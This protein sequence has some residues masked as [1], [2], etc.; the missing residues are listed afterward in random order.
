MCSRRS[1]GQVVDQEFHLVDQDIAVGQDQVLHPAGPV[2]HRQQRHI[3][4]LGRAV[5]LAQV[6]VQA[7]ADH[8]FPGV[9]AVLGDRQHMVAGQLAAAEALAAVH[10]QVAVAGEQGGIGERRRRVDGVVAAVAGAGDDGVQG[11]GALQAADTVVAAVDG[12]AGIAQGPR[13]GVA[14]VEA[15]RFLPADPVKNS[16]GGVQRQHAGRM[17]VDDAS[18][19][20]HQHA[21]PSFNPGE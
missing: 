17:K 11:Q 13:H 1:R 3:G 12:D 16:A 18:R 20:F 6:A 15:N 7:G 4:L 10:A 19:Y 8:V 21:K 2:G 14:Y 9:L 5:A